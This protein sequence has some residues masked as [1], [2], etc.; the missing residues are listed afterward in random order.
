MKK[1]I[2]FTFCLL[3][4][5]SMISVV[6]ASKPGKLLIWSDSKRIE[7]L[8]KIVD[9]FEKEYG[10]PIVLQEKAYDNLN[11]DFTVQAPSGEGPDIIIISHDPLGELISNGLL[12]A[13]DLGD[14]T[15][16]FYKVAIDAFKW[17]D[18]LYGLPYAIESI[19]LIYNKDIIPE[20]PKN[21]AAFEEIIRK[22]TN[23][24]EGRYAFAMPQPD[25]YHTFPF[26]SACGGYVFGEKNGVLDPTDVGLNNSGA[27]YG[28]N[29]LKN[30]YQEGLIPYV[31]YNDMESLFVQGKVGMMI[32]GPWAFGKLE[33]TGINFG[34]AQIPTIEGN[35]PKP[36]V[37]VQGFMI[38][39][40][41]ENKMLA[42]AFLTEFIAQKDIL[43][44]FYKSDKR[45]LAYIPAAEEIKVDPIVAGLLKSA[46]AGIPMPKIPEM[47][48]VWSAWTD[49]L[50]L[51][52]TQKQETKPAL[53]DAVNRISKK[54]TENK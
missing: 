9:R 1:I 30:L 14:K 48:A 11:K 45:P 47:T 37:G 38:S 27:V 44:E 17:G 53:D 15:N 21:W 26:M 52:L 12:E 3:V 25:P 51:I 43:L 16:D 20:P 32:T 36:F 5:V 41:S 28:L 4:L 49:A 8:D 33:E 34:F 6:F 7:V 39:S 31:D 35:E 19:G 54:I 13:I 42:K 22:T 46:S 18:K 10:V 2:L 23:K 50:E 40:F 24:K 29:K